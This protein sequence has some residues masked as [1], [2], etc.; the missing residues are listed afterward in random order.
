[1]MVYDLFQVFFDGLM[2]EHLASSV[3][4]D[5]PFSGYIGNITSMTQGTK[6]ILKNVL[7]V[8]GFMS[9]VI[10]AS[11]AWRGNSRTAGEIVLA[12]GIIIEVLVATLS[13]FGN[14]N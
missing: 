11:M 1:M 2:I 8:L 9:I 10:G 4:I 5:D 14:I 3:V 13:F 12:V 7:G 6:S